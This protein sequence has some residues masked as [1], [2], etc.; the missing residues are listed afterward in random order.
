MDRS[1]QN[2]LYFVCMPKMYDHFK[3]SNVHRGFVGKLEKVRRKSVFF[4]SW[5]AV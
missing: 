2:D 5:L 1:G 4:S 3:I